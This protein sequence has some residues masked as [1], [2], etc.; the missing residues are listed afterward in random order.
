MSHTLH[1]PYSTTLWVGF[2][3]L[4][5]GASRLIADM[6]INPR[7][8]RSLRLTWESFKHENFKP[9]N[10]RSN[11]CGILR[12][13]IRVSMALNQGQGIPRYNLHVVLNVS[14]MDIRA[15]KLEAVRF[16]LP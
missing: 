14:I 9:G 11:Y 15:S 7:R 5:Q 13:T 4:E 16:M 12:G 1:G 10:R 8:S 6:F 2:S 3:T